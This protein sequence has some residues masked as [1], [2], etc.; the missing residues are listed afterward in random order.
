MSDITAQGGASSYPITGSVW[1]RASTR[2]WVLEIN[3]TINDT[4]FSYRHTEPASTKPEDVAG[5][6]TIYAFLDRVLK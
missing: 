3:G 5:L 1:F 6:P 2:E 4:N